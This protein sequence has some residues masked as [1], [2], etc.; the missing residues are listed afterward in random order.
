MERRMRTRERNALGNLMAGPG[1]HAR[2]AS[3]G[4]GGTGGNLYLADSN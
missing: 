4:A 2:S 1:D 3:L